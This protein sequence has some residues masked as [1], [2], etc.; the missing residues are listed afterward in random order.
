MHKKTEWIALAALA[1]SA[2]ACEAEERKVN[3]DGDDGCVDSTCSAECQE[4][5]H[6][7]GSCNEEGTCVCGGGDA[8]TDSDSDTESSTYPPTGICDVDILFVYDTSGSMMDAVPDLTQVA[9]PAFAESLVTYPALG[10]I[11]VG[12]TNNLYGVIE[13]FDPEINHSEFYTKGWPVG[14]G[15]DAFN[16][17]EIPTV[18]CDFA[19]GES[20]MVG[21]SSTFIDE[22]QCAG[23]VPCQQDVFFKEQTL[24]AG[25]E[26]L[27]FAPNAAFLRPEALLVLVFITDEDDQSQMSYQTVHDQLLELKGGDEKYIVSVTIGGPLVGTVEVNSITHAMGCISSFYGATEET[28]KIIGFT[29][30]WGERGRHYNL[31]EDDLQDALTDALDRLEL[32]C[33]E[34]IVE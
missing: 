16:C 6:D 15:H 31:C 28:P 8:D 29:E 25:L 23:N 20:W 2:W 17:E 32:S 13:N 7:G 3:G 1:A 19:S 11:H 5:G 21:P 24:Q 30:L 9:F 33:D 22:F 18:D 14:Q 12:I 26:A 34:I 10:T 27:R 4:L